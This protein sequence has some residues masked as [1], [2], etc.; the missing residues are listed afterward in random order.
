[1]CCGCV[2][3]VHVHIEGAI[4]KMPLY[5]II[6]FRT[7]FRTNSSLNASSLYIPKLSKLIL[8]RYV[9]RHP[10]TQHS[11]MKIVVKGKSKVIRLVSKKVSETLILSD[12]YS[13]LYI[14]GT[15]NVSP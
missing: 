11:V 3:S 12:K 4:L 6:V 9:A 10:K 5:T 13:Q 2:V 14:R 8:P 15:S 7:L 1:M